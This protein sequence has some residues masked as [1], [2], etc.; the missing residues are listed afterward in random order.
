MM[1]KEESLPKMSIG[2]QLASKRFRYNSAEAN[3]EAQG[4][5]MST[6]T[7]Y[8]LKARPP[9]VEASVQKSRRALEMRTAD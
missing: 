7:I 5:G 3:G 9:A 8:S 6:L 4:S 1:T 2:S